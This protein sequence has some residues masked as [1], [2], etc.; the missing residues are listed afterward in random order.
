M[1]YQS[2]QIVFCIELVSHAF[3]GSLFIERASS[4]SVEHLK[5]LACFRLQFIKRRSV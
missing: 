1:S 4:L 5:L 2:V 3:Q